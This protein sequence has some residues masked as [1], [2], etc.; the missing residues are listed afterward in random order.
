MI[1]MESRVFSYFTTSLPL[2]ITVS[3]SSRVKSALEQVLLHP[4]QN[5]KE[6]KRSGS[7]VQQRRKSWDPFKN[8]DS[9]GR[10]LLKNELVKLE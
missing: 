9:G 4:W 5:N 6:Y 10:T 8:R 7:S 3:I 1:G 2:E